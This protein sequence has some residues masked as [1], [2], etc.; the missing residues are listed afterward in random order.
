MA[1][2]VRITRTELDASGLRAQA[3]LAASAAAARRM[4][5]LAA[6]LDG[7]R[8]SDAARLAG[9]DRQTL[10]DWVHRYNEH[11]L[12]GLEDRR[13]GARPRRLDTAQE[14][15]FAALVEAGPA[16]AADGVVRWRLVDLR[17]VLIARF[18]V[19]YHLASVARLLH[20]LGLRRL[21][22]RPHHPKRDLDAQAAFKKTSRAGRPRQSRRRRPA[23]R[24]KSG[25]R[26]KPGSVSKAP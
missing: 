14:A 24:S 20:R 15:A 10:R 6:V 9:M 25:S 4:L 7:H 21:V 8:R 13:G 1:T 17:G 16:L 3:V 23:S 26:T 18:G 22:V 5:A 2:G 12:A 19:R 11:G